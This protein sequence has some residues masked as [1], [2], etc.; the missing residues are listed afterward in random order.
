MA[1]DT[2]AVTDATFDDE[3]I[4][5]DTPVVVDFWAEWCGPCQMLG[6]VVEKLATEYR[7]QLKFAKVDVDANPQT[8]G[9]Y[10]IRGIPTMIIFR[11]GE[12]VD[13]I[14]GYLPEEQL[15]AELEKQLQPA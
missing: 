2:I 13:R 10:G 4:H 11:G 6:P 15:R 12:E 3:V 8:P 7:G 1:G 5:A 14:V 9:S